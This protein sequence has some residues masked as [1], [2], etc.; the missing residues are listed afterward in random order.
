MAECNSILKLFESK[1]FIV[2]VGLENMIEHFLI[3][4]MMLKLSK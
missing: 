4:I 1:L 3:Q 2:N